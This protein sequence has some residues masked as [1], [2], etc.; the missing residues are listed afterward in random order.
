MDSV[1]VRGID[2]GS[3]HTVAL[4][5]ESR[6]SEMTNGHAFDIRTVCSQVVTSWLHLAGERTVSWVMAMQIRFSSRGPSLLSMGKASG[7]CAVE[8]SIVWQ[9]GRTRCT[10]GDG[11]SRVHAS[12]GA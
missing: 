2:C 5:S 1:C 8:R 9:W 12:L 11:K 6:P 4:L 7:W 3:A 10:H